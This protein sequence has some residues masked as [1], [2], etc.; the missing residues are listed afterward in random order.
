MTGVRR[1]A[2][3]RDPL[4]RDDW[5]YVEKWSLA[6]FRAP[7]WQL[8]NRQRAEYMKDQ[9]ARQVL[10][11]F[12]A[13]RDAPTFGYAINNYEH[14]LQTATLLARDGHDE[15]TVVCGLLH[16]VGFVVCPENHGAFA[17]ELLRS[18]VSERN[19]WTLERHQIFQRV[20]LHEYEGL[21]D[22][23][24][25]NECERWRGHPHFGWAAEFVEKYDIATIDPAVESMPLSAFEPMVRRIFARPPNPLPRLE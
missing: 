16:D 5:R 24:I 1:R 2:G 12:A 6:D 3:E 18:F 17:A 9:Q 7:D 23:G 15:E 8:M 22:P 10:D 20:H 11:L 4:L 21:S 19:V 13:S 25:V 14:G